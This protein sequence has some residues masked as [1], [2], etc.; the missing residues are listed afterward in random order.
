MAV[1]QLHLFHC[2]FVSAA[3]PSSVIDYI[4][5]DT[6]PIRPQ[7]LMVM[8]VLFLMMVVLMMMTA[9]GGGLCIDEFLI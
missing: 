5:G 4:R 6:A 8:V 1:V 7:R 2:C 9:S 3:P